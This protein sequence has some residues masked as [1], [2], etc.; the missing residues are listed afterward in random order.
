MTSNRLLIYEIVLSFVTLLFIILG[1][2][3]D[4][5]F[6]TIALFTGSAMLGLMAA[7]RFIE[8]RKVFG[9]IIVLIAI[10]VFLS[11]VVEFVV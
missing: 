2:F 1:W 9:A 4:Q 11:G 10:F 3:A 7:R 5:I 8:G 6:I